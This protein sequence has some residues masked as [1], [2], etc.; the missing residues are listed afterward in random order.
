LRG[1]AFFLLFVQK[2]L[3]PPKPKT[4]LKGRRL[5][6]P[7]D[8]LVELGEVAGRSSGIEAAPL[9]RNLARALHPPSISNSYS[10]LPKPLFSDNNP[11]QTRPMPSISTGLGSGIVFSVEKLKVV[12]D[13]L[14]NE[15]PLAAIKSNTVALPEAVVG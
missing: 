14:Q 3:G 9:S 10:N 8:R 2:E 12:G 15:V 4:E 5:V 11:T 13:P 6:E 7:G 1:A